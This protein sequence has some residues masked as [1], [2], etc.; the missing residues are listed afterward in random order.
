MCN[1]L[2]KNRIGWALIALVVIVGGC[3]TN[4]RQSPDVLET[5]QFD[6]LPQAEVG[7]QELE[8][9][10]PRSATDLLRAANEAFEQANKAQEAGDHETALRHYTLMLELLIEADPDPSVFYSLRTK[11][12]EILEAASEGATLAR[13]EPRHEWRPGEFTSPVVG[14]LPIPFPP[15]ERII[16]EIEKI[17]SLYPKN[18]QAG[19][20]RGAKYIPVLRKKFA[21][22]GL[23][24]DLVWLAMVESLCQPRIVSRAGAGGMW[25]FMPATGRRYGLHVDSYV[26]DRY[27]WEKATDAAIKYLRD[28]NA[29]FDGNWPL[30]ISAYNMGEHGLERAIAASGGERDLWRLLETSAADQY[31]RL[32]T[33][34]FYAKLC[35]SVLVGRNPERYGFT[36]SQE[37]PD[38]IVRVAVK[39]SYSLDDIAR[40]SGVQK[41]VLKALNPDLLRGVTPPHGEHLVAVPAPSR[42]QVAEA[43]VKIPQLKPQVHVVKRGETV[44]QI[45]SRHGVSDSELMRANKITNPRSLQVGKQLVIPGALASASAKNADSEKPAAADSKAAAE[46]VT[47]TASA[48]S[49]APSRRTYKVRSGDCLF[50]IA[51]KERVTM[52]DL[53]AWNNLNRQSTIRVGQVLYVSAPGQTA[54]AASTSQGEK[55]VHLVQRGECPGTIASRYKVALGDLLKWNNLSSKSTI[56][57]GQRLT[58][59]KSQA[60]EGDSGS[61]QVASTDRKPQVHKVRRGESAWTIASKYGVK[62]RE[63]FEWNGWTKEPV[64][65]VGT[66]VVVFQ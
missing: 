2:T 6:P 26:D 59:Y 33:K 64:L 42:T 48:S 29:M 60:S 41:D 1:I 11:L 31:I 36:V 44:S 7:R 28:L 14:E 50:D 17:Q 3:A 35:A 9:V 15:N 45:A 57:A 23:P 58:V 56:R 19:L 18:F 46:P 13:R 52:S 65:Q 54:A 32:E 53:Q 40:H 25:Q 30:A 51:K 20:D 5:H 55:V 8:P 63:L 61:I 4:T 43:L 27:N 12:S 22:A 66:E 39:G 24:E 10:E 34:E 62:L 37:Q 16:R 47:V 38:D 21:D 49:E